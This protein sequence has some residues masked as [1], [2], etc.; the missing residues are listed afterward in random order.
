MADLVYLPNKELEAQAFGI[1][2]R[3]LEKD[4][5]RKFLPQLKKAYDA[6]DPWS[7]SSQRRLERR[8]R[9]AYYRSR[10]ELVESWQ[11]ETLAQWKIDCDA[12][13]ESLKKG[14][15]DE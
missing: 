12:F 7:E 4:L 6:T 1:A 14:E 13:I 8:I 5:R 9:A 2:L 11:P 15:Q 10:Y 3:Q